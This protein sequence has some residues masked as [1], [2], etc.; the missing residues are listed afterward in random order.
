MKKRTH[1]RMSQLILKHIEDKAP[2]LLPSIGYQRVFLW[3]SVEPDLSIT[4]F[5]TPHF[6]NKS[7]DKIYAKIDELFQKEELSMWDMYQMGRLC[8]YLSD[9]CCYAHIDD[10]IGN[11][12]DHVLYELGLQNY[13]FSH[14]EEFSRGR[15]LLEP[16]VD[17]IPFTDA[18]ICEYRKGESNYA[19]DIE[20]AM[21]LSG[22]FVYNLLLG[23][24]VVDPIKDLEELISL[25]LT[26]LELNP[27]PQ[28]I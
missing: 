24:N 20:L 4:Q 28:G 2:H 1:Y 14:V 9:F 16:T 27:A 15:I 26:Q 3:G 11:P 5:T 18:L 22:M 21:T 6:W 19:R 23:E 8:H 17:F 13:L 7:K 10:R 25:F 12:K